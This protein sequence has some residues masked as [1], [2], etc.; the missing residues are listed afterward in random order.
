MENK[1]KNKREKEKKSWK[2]MVTFHSGPGRLLGDSIL[3]LVH[4][5]PAP[6]R[7]SPRM[8]ALSPLSLSS[9]VRPARDWLPSPS[10]ERRSG[11]PGHRGRG[12]AHVRAGTGGETRWQGRGKGEW[13]GKK[14]ILGLEKSG[15][16]R[17]ETS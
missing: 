10:P 15:G 7:R 11:R 6:A 4:A 17:R 9:Q 2:Q 14:K 12:G 16:P 13:Q 3:L 8:P 1:N 5:A